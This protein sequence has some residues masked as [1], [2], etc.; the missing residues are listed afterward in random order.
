MKEQESIW[1][2]QYKQSQQK[3]KLTTK[4]LPNLLKDKQILE[5]GV[6]NGKTLNA[7]LR[8]KPKSVTAIDFSEES[9][10]QSTKTFAQQGVEF[11]KADV[12]NLPLSDSKFDVVVCY[13]V[14]NNL[15]EAERK[16]VVEEI[17][18][19]LKVGGKV[20][21]EDFAQGDFRETETK[22]KIEDHTIENKNGIVCH[23]FNVKE[24]NLLFKDF[25]KLKFTKKSS[26]PIT[27]KPELKRQVVSGIVVR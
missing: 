10:K 22:K 6:G 11:V 21:F 26:E 8:Q 25:N 1:D 14:L 13:Y 5:L 15:L 23:F 4:T 2:G 9:I 3:W 24:L 17:K 7:I 12:T 16:K 18:R 27:H 20:L 19:V